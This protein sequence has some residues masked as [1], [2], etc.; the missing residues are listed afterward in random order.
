MTQEAYARIRA[1]VDELENVTM[2]Q[3]ASDVAAARD[4][5]D[6]KE[7]AEYHACLLYTSPSPRD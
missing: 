5:G 7:N 3:I 6:L 2:P 4:E 1:E